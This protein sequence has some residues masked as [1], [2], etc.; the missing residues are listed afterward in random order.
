MPF[1]EHKQSGVACSYLEKLPMENCVSTSSPCSTTTNYHKF[2]GSKKQE[3]V[4]CNLEVRSLTT[5]CQQ[6][7]TPSRWSRRDSF[8]PL[9]ASGGFRCSFA[10][11]CISPTSSST[12]KTSQGLLTCVSLKRTL[13]TGLR[14]HQDNPV[15][16]DFDTLFLIPFE[17]LLC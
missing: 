17:E 13:V 8:L 16:L 12:K 15:C 4:P 1:N 6:E 7:H 10:S 5:R 2:D 11:D 9:L 3:L 14:L